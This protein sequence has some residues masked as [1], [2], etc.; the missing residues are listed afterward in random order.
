MKK[1]KRSDVTSEAP[2]DRLKTLAAGVFAIVVTLLVLELGVGEIAET[3]SSAGLLHG[4]LEMWPH[5]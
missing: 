1:R 3:S 4:L 5:S 2:P